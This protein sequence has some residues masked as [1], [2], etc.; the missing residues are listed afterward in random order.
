[1]NRFAATDAGD[2]AGTLE[3]PLPTDADSPALVEAVLRELAGH[4]A[5]LAARPDRPSAI[6]LRSLPISDPDR[7]A[8]RRRLG[9]GEV[10][11]TL[12]LSGT[13]QIDETAYAG[14]WWVRH[15]AADGGVLAE[16]I[17]VARVPE[18]L[19]AHPDDIDAAAR[20]L[21]QQL[22]ADAAPGDPEE[23]ADG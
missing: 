10:R 8:L 22:G 5:A 9:A 3:A 11:A 18:L 15:D 12:T 6:D 13:S 23:H 14:V 4:L 2:A 17:V 20:R 7:Q 16:Q 19:L 21:Q 1:M